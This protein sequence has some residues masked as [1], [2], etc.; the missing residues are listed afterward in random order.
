[1]LVRCVDCG[2]LS[3][4][5]DGLYVLMGEA[6]WRPMHGERNA[7]LD[8]RCPGCWLMFRDGVGDALAPSTN[9]LAAAPNEPPEGRVGDGAEH[10]EDR[11]DTVLA[12]SGERATVGDAG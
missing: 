8:W 3:P 5:T 6:G 9:F 2:S 10:E 7:P 11:W 12:Q 4:K 1:M